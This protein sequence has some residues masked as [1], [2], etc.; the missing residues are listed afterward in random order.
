MIN[1]KDLIS[2]YDK[3][4]SYNL[5]Y[6]PRDVQIE[7]LDF[8][9][10]QIRHGKKYMMLNSPTGTGKSF[11]AV[12]FIN[13][14]LNHINPDARFD[15]LTNSKILQNQY[16]DEFPFMCSLKGRNS[17]TC[18]TYNCSCQEGKEKNKA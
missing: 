2:M 3:K 13:W 18:H 7:A 8:I 11:F 16:T 4:I 10:Y 9:K 6:E 15:I 5:K 1:K 14:Y 12:M 17:Y